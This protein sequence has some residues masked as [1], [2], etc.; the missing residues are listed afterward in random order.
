MLQEILLLLFAVVL[1]AKGDMESCPYGGTVQ[2]SG[3]CL[4]NFYL[5]TFKEACFRDE[6]Y[7]L[8]RH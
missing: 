1:F 2:F 4:V 8:F 7:N 5:T 6:V 3:Y